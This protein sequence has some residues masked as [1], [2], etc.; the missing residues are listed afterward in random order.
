MGEVEVTLEH[1]T[2]SIDI[3][4]VHVIAVFSKAIIPSQLLLNMPERIAVIHHISLK[5]RSGVRE[6][7]GKEGEGDRGANRGDG[8]SFSTVEY[9]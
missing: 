5:L 6:R 7:I 2:L 8:P 1:C 3:V 4:L 9:H